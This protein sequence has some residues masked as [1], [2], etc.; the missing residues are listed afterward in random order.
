MIGS[1]IVA[2]GLGKLGE[3]MSSNDQYTG[4]F[5]GQYGERKNA[6]GNPAEDEDFDVLRVF[7]DGTGRFHDEIC[8]VSCSGDL[9][10]G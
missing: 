10:V 2:G 9:F 6:H 7:S 5:V 8:L 3:G 4:L 1:N